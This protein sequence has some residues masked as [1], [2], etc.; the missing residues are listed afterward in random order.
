MRNIHQSM[1]LWCLTTAGPAVSTLLPGYPELRIEIS[2]S[3]GLIDI[4]AERYDA[5]L[6]VAKDVAPAVARTEAA[7][8]IPT[9]FVRSHLAPFMRGTGVNDTSSR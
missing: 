5:E 7:A 6:V 4:V 2:I 1:Q 8:V 9:I 3:Y